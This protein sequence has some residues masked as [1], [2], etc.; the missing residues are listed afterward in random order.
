MLSET[1]IRSS[2]RVRAC[3]P[4]CSAV[5]KLG[6]FVTKFFA[7]SLTC[8]D[9][10]ATATTST[11]KTTM[12]DNA[13]ATV[14]R[15]VVPKLLFSNGRSISRTSGFIRYDNKIASTT[16]NSRLVNEVTTNI[17]TSFAAKSTRTINTTRTIDRAEGEDDTS[18][19]R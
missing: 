1:R 8:G 9:S 10:T 11:P 3:I 15:I 19:T 13:I 12:K 16:M 6:I 5:V 17:T 14:R 2:R 18:A 7:C 4:D